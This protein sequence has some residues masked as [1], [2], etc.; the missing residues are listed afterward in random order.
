MKQQ[1]KGATLSNW[2]VQLGE[3]TDGVTVGAL[4]T[5]VNKVIGFFRTK[6]HDPFTRRDIV[7]LLGEMGWSGDLLKDG[8]EWQAISD[9]IGNN[10][11]SLKVHN[12]KKCRGY[13]T[14]GGIPTL[15][16][17]DEPKQPSRD[18]P[19]TQELPANVEV[20][21][22]TGLGWA[23]TLPEVNPPDSEPDEM[24]MEDLELT[25]YGQDPGLRQMAIE[26]TP[27]F[28]YHLNSAPECGG[29]LLR[30]WCAQ[31]TL[32]HLREVA[33]K[34]DD[35]YDAREQRLKAPPKTTSVEDIIAP[36]LDASK[37]DAP[38]DPV[39]DL[40]EK[41][42]AK[43]GKAAVTMITSPF[44]A[45]C[46]KCDE[47]IKKSEQAVHVDTHGMLHMSCAQSLL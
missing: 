18:E 37:A 32:S 8:E 22:K 9:C 45:V 12:G 36:E 25:L 5:D 34:L 28:G 11:E 38:A 40:Q 46:S 29:C 30:S 42:E 39:A 27:C 4:T 19:K 23:P 17:M 14:F 6:G 1:I 26:Q 10:S 41:L 33:K 31:S 3:K 2:G 24:S 47:N 44:E 15:P 13:Y 35:A 16:S 7:A 20:I 21:E 43:F